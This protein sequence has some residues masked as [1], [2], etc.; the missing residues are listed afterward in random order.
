MKPINRSLFL[1]TA[2]CPVLGW[3]IYRNLVKKNNSVSDEFLIFEAKNIHEKAKRLF[4]DAVQVTGTLQE[5]IEQT[6]KFLEDNSIQTLLEPV[7]EYDGFIAKADILTKQDNYWQI[8]EVKSG[9]K[10]K[11]KYISDIAYNCL[12]ASKTI[13][14]IS[15]AKLMLLSKDFRLGMP[16]E[17][18]F[19]VTDCTLE[20]FDKV[21]EY[22]K[23]LVDIKN[24]LQSDTCSEPSLKNMC[25]NCDMFDVCMGKDI[26]YHIFDL[27]RLSILV[28]NELAKQKIYQIKDVPENT[29]LTQMQKV[30]RDC[31]I[32]DKIYVN[33]NLKFELDKIAFPCYYLDFESVMTIYPLYDNIAPH[34]QILTQYS[35]HKCSKPD[36]IIGHFEYIADPKKNCQKIIAQNLVNILENTGSIITYSSFEAQVIEKLINVVPELEEQL[37]NIIS[38]IVDLEAILKFNYYDKR[39]HGRTSIKKVLPVMIPQMNYDHL[40]IGEGGSALSMFAYM[41]MGMYSKEKEEEIKKNLL[42]YCK[43]DTLA[44]VKMHKFLDDASKMAMV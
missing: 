41:A 44:L 33:P 28:F 20:V 26:E 43:R 27:P 25:K 3:N 39:F 34:T 24:I 36:D 4:P 42:E 10:W 12:I 6:K 13:N 15:K 35:I 29:D 38:R 5:S 40:K 30:V 14:C 18:L 23:H 7:F 17:K 32:N 31:V 22:N 37:R 16:I 2:D 19:S 8:I 9:N 1:K 11:N 21:E